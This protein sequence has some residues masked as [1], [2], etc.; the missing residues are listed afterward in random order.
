M[1]ARDRLES[2]LRRNRA[3]ILTDR[4]VKLM[5]SE[6]L[7]FMGPQYAVLFADKGASFRN[8]VRLTSIGTRCR[9]ARD[10]RGLDLRGASAATGIPQYRLRA[11]EQGSLAYIT[12]DLAAKYFRFLNIGPWVQRWARA[13]RDLAASLGVQLRRGRRQKKGSRGRAI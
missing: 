13:N 4:E 6:A 1:D 8:I 3:C 7:R 12:P 10:E 11:I 9:Q 2:K 5:E